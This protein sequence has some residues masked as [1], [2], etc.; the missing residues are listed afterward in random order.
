MNLRTCEF[1]V[2]IS[3]L[4]FG[5]DDHNAILQ[6]DILFDYLEGLGGCPSELQ[7]QLKQRNKVFFVGNTFVTYVTGDGKV[8]KFRTDIAQKLDEALHQLSV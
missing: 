5:R 6:I 2:F 1:Q 4:E 8:K 7:D 3:G